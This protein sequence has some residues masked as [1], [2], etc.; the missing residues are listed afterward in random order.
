MVQSLTSV[1]SRLTTTSTLL[2]ERSRILSLNLPPSAASTAQIARN[3]TTLRNDIAGLEDEVELEAAGLAVGGRKRGK[4]MEGEMERAV[5]EAGERY[6]GLIEMFEEGDDV[7]REKAR[8]LKR[9]V[10]RLVDCA[11][12]QIQNRAMKPCPASFLWFPGQL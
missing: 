6:D 11:H 8:G 3:L 2:L 7:G 5:R 9:E 10:K 1:Q 4:G 12:T